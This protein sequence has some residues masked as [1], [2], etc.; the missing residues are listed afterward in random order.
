MVPWAV[1]KRQTHIET[2]V[3]FCKIFQCKTN[4][5]KIRIFIIFFFLLFHFTMSF[6]GAFLIH[7]ISVSHE[8]LLISI[9][10]CWCCYCLF[11][12]FLESRDSCR[13]QQYHFLTNIYALHKSNANWNWKISKLTFNLKLCW[14]DIEWK[15]VKKKKLNW[16][17]SD[18]HTDIGH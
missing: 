15:K 2:A 13:I 16:R 18:W 5:Q 1:I 10:I 6:A 12:F 9:G 14:I 4:T 7:F 8:C 11:F 3:V 17:K